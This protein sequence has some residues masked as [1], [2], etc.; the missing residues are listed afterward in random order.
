VLGES[1]GVGL[2]CAYAYTY[3]HA[4]ED[5]GALVMFQTTDEWG[6]AAA[7]AILEVLFWRTNG[8]SYEAVLMSR[9]SEARRWCIW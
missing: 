9:G 2:K 1:D 8:H 5:E 4:L 7:A 6:F 3:L